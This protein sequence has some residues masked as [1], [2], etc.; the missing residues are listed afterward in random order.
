MQSQSVDRRSFLGRLAGAAGAAALIA[1]T[2]GCGSVQQAL[3]PK[4]N[5]PP[6]QPG[7]AASGSTS[8][9]SGTAASSG[10]APAAKAGTGAASSGTPAAS[11]A[12]APAQAAA[13]APAT[14][15]YMGH[16][17]ALGDTA[18]DR[19]QKQ[20]DEKFKQAVPGITIQW[21][22]TAWETIGEKYMAAWSANTAPDISL[23]SP[24]NLAQAVRLGSLED[25]QPSF[26]TWSEQDKKDLSQAWWDTGTY[27]G[28]KY[29]APLLLFGD[30]ML[31]RKSLFDA[32][33]VNITE[34]K[35]WKQYTEALQKVVVD[36]QGRHPTDAGFD[37]STVKV[38]GWHQ[39]L[40]RGS[41]AGIPHLAEFTW[42]RL[43][44]PDLGPP[45]WRADHWASPEI[46]E[47]VQMVVDWVTKD[48]IQP[49]SSLTYNL[50]DADNSFVSGQ[51]AT[52]QFG[53]HRY[54]SWR[55]KMQFPPEDA[56][57][58]RYPTWDGKKWGP[59]L[60]NHWSMGVSSKSKFKDQAIAATT[61]WMSPDADL[62]MSDVAGQQP[63]RSS[64]TKN[65]IFDR[66]DLSFVKLF[67]QASHE[68]S[69]P[70]TN[71]P[72]RP[73]D[74]QIQAYDQMVND[75]VPVQKALSDARDA[76]NQLL[77]ELPKD[78]LPK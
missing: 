2:A 16:F 62:I 49:R 43:N 44:K 12:A 17:T 75:G 66:P 7:Q 61:Y 42:D 73:S 48:K 57:W 56:V 37:E 14:I 29:I 25:L 19:A 15:R 65:P 39:F 67:D 33:G 50:E 28:K 3:G 34:I 64:I 45:D 70:L 40:A 10:G 32:A 11:G 52:Y 30:M 51:V 53:T 55:E 78:Q 76:Y 38:W 36:A 13:V 21:E 59:V 77:D 47:A 4:T 22:Q 31:Y 8:S 69:E 58:G 1:A 26:S 6:S 9:G 68:W 23:F 27:D 24:A 41:G 46:V 74:I 71:P 18:R 63:R 60:V 20:I 54:G 35:T 72:I 5:P